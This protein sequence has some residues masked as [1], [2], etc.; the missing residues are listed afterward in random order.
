[1]PELKLGPTYEGREAKDE[2]R[3][4]KDEGRNLRRLKL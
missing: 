2:G 1:M 3:R 4:T